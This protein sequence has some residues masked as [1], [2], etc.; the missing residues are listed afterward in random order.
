M[1]NS[2]GQGLFAEGMSGGPTVKQEEEF[3]PETVLSEDECKEAI[4]FMNHSADVLTIKL[5]AGL[6]V[7]NYFLSIFSVLAY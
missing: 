7:F 6:Y 3:T 2:S 5:D 4:A 1:L